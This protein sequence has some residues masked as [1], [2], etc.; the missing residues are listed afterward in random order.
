V[1]ETG[2]EIAV[3]G[4]RGSRPLS[5]DEMKS[6]YLDLNGNPWYV[7]DDTHPVRTIASTR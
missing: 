6:L 7:P 2:N 5:P 4:R 1:D 3:F